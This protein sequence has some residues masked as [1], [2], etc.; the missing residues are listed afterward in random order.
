MTPTDTATVTPTDTATVTWT[1]TATV[2]WTDTATVTPTDTATVTPTDR[3][4][5][6]DTD[7]HGNSDMDRHGNSDMDRH[8]N[9]DM[10]RHSN[11]A[12]DSH[13][14]RTSPGEA[15]GARPRPVAPGT[16]PMIT[17][18]DLEPRRQQLKEGRRQQTSYKTHRKKT[19]KQATWTHRTAAMKMTTTKALSTMQKTVSPTETA[20]EVIPKTKNKRNTPH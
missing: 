8:G 6:S 11:S 13:Q 20:P 17:S 15:K 7:R 18:S 5:N 9:S 1:D 14:D 12:H 10:D 3:H 19:N 16:P 4:G 2:T